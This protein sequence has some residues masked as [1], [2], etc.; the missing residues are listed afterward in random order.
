MADGTYLKVSYAEKDKVKSIGAKWDV[1][2]KKWYVPY[3]TD[4]TPFK[5][6]LPKNSDL[7]SLKAKYLVKSN[8]FYD[9]INRIWKD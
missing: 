2:N 8:N 5:Q 1:D 4:I 6:W 7:E 3:N 9:D